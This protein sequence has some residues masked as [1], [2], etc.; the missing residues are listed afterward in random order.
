MTLAE[1]IYDDS[2]GGTI[3][4]LS[5]HKKTFKFQ[6]QSVKSIHQ[7]FH[8]FRKRVVNIAISM[9]GLVSNERSDNFTFFIFTN[10]LIPVFLKGKTVL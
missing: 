4:S 3:S 8:F 2:K 1:E 6:V 7:Y 9:L 5:Y 10:L